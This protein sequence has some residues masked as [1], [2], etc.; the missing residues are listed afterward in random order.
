MGA[1]LLPVTVYGSRT[2]FSRI[3]GIIQFEDVEMGCW[4]NYLD[5]WGE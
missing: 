2:W 4:K 5:L 3:K 1:M